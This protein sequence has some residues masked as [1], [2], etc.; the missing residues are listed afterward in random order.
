VLARFV[1]G[2]KTKTKTRAKVKG[3]SIKVVGRDAPFI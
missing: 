1:V 2:T 3:K